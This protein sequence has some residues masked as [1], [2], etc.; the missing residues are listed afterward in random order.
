MARSLFEY[1]VY[2]LDMR[3]IVDFRLKPWADRFLMLRAALYPDPDGGTGNKKH[4]RLDEAQGMG[5]EGAP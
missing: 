1:L 2:D 4:P 3:R 5:N